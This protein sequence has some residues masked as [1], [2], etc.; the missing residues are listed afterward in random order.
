MGNSEQD[1]AQSLDV[2]EE[3]VF[4]LVILRAGWGKAQCLCPGTDEVQVLHQFFDKSP[5]VLHSSQ[6]ASGSRKLRV[7]ARLF[8]QFQKSVESLCC[9]NRRPK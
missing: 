2:P 7:D 3:E 5:H 8:V 4:R 9:P 6:N 1:L